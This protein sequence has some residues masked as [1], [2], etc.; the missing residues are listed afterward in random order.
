M[1]TPPVKKKLPDVKHSSTTPTKAAGGPVHPHPP[2]VG[3][4]G[5]GGHGGH[6][7][8]GGGGGGHGGG[9]AGKPSPWLDPQNEPKP[10]KTASFVEYLR[11]MREYNHP[12]R[13][14]TKIEI[15]DKAQEKADYRERL[16]QLHKRTRLIAGKEN[17]FLVKCSWRIRVGGHRGPESILLP[18]F[19]ALGMPYI[20]SSTLRG[21][22][23]TQAIREIM[24]NQNIVG[25]EARKK[26]W[27]E[28]EKKIAPY[29]GDINTKNKAD[30][31][32]KVIF[33]DAY[34]LADDEE[35]SAGLS[36]DMAN[37][38]WQWEGEQL[39]YSPNPNIFFSLK[40]PVFCIG[41]RLAS[42]CQ[43]PAV[44]E[45]VKQWLILGLQ[46]GVGSQVNT[47]YGELLIENPSKPTEEFLRVKFT[48]EGQLIHGAQK[49]TQ[50][51][52]NRTGQ[53]QMKGKAEAEVRSIAF[54]SMLRYW[55]RAFA[56]GVLSV[57]EVKI[58]EAQLFGAI[59][60]QKRGW[61]KFEIVNGKVTQGEPKGKNDPCGKEVGTLTLAYSPALPTTYHTNIETLFKSLTWLM[62]HLG[63]IGQGAR[64]PCYS[65]QNRPNAPWF[66][67]STFSIQRNDPYWKLP[68]TVQEFKQLFQQRL[69]EFYTSLAQIT[70]INIDPS[71]LKT[72]GTVN[73]TTWREAIDQNC[74]IVVCSGNATA[75][76]K[77]YALSTLHSPTFNPG[78]N[79][80]PNLCGSVQG[81]VKPSPVWI[82][83]LDEY[84]VVTVF[85]ATANP[86][87]QYLT[88]LEDNAQK[89]DQIFPLVP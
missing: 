70:S 7:G 47:G 82:S 85:G 51:T 89:Y 79:Y 35:K 43:D 32:G 11:W 72:L 53:W 68:S 76:N 62:F 80:N 12:H 22:A 57:P 63:G 83:D 14:G 49:F 77:P 37:N 73:Q 36:M 33:F 69:N 15:L 3:G 86:R 23:R 74:S 5:G 6:G 24:A 48:L 65:R 13:D 50:W 66:R 44:L 29:F 19:D 56:L 67:G 75:S 55:F 27:E 30:L 8:H 45:K 17:T 26:A 21:V 52:Q 88:T 16:K 28:A 84:Q 40:E 9:H 1:A 54:K 38:I 58:W 81:V 34:P 2:V 59:E 41:L 4:G 61:V 39:K 78:G 20:P 87:Q 18:A 60:P 64:R 10:D 42:N 46:S 25:K 31:Q 71:N